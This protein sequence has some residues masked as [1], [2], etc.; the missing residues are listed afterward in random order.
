MEDWVTIK[1]LK[2]KNP[3][4]GTRKIALM[5]GISR[6]TVKGA[7]TAVFKFQYIICFGSSVVDGVTSWMDEQFQYI[8]CFGSSLYL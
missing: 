1:N 2:K 8:I 7:M 3:N 4:L 6:N 5:L